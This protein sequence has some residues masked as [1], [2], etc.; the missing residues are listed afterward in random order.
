M[1]GGRVLARNTL[2]NLLGLGAPMLAALV[3]MPFLIHGLGTERFG[4]L[5]MAWAVIGYFN[6]FDLG[7]GRALTQLAAE[8]LGAEREG[9]IPALTWT[10]VSLMLGLGAVGAV[11]LVALTPWLT[12]ELLRIP[13][14]LQGEAAT[15]FYLLALSLPWVTSTAGLRGLLEAKQRFAV[16]NVI[17]LPLGLL[18]YFGPLAVLPFS[19][20]LV[21]VVLV[22]VAGRILTWLVHLWYCVSTVPA[23]RHGVQVERGLVGPLLRFGGWMTASNVA[24]ALMVYLD[25]FVIGAVLSMAAV[26]YYVTPYEMASRLG[27]LPGALLA[28]VF[29]AV[30]T[31]FVRERERA[32]ALSDASLRAVFLVL[33]PVTLVVVTGAREGLQLWLGADFARH[34]TVVLQWIAVGVFV[35]A[36]GT[37]P[38]S[39]IQGTGRPE[40]TGKLNLVE[41]P[42]Y[43]VV[44]WLLLGRFGLVGAAV[45]WVARVAV[46]TAILLV[47][48]RRVSLLPAR[49]FRRTWLM[50]AAALGTFAAAA[51]LQE[52]V[53]KLAFL[54]VALGCFVP[55]AW[56]RVLRASERS[57]VRGL[58]LAFPLFRPARRGA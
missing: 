47:L 50:M 8:R 23:L 5:T 49:T 30:A 10:A 26:A 6:L 19:T 43:L 58:L 29:P 2:W 14:E 51:A 42:F 41:L 40:I 56:Q 52:P 34:S 24:S 37:V 54:V 27:M 4:V 53:A 17:R 16:L 36:M 9:E 35:N 31:S 15:T 28:A 25:R 22:L 3:A 32:E 12:R 1:A 7:L 20:S 11:V 57:G 38:A 48:V 44:L 39:A 33:F 21:P 45:A 46:D 18:T 13:T 55:L